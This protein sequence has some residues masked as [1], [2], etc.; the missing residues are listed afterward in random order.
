M[1]ANPNGTLLDVVGQM[2]NAPRIAALRG[3]VHSAMAKCIGAIRQDIRDRKRAERN[4]E[5]AQTDIDQRNQR[6]EDHR[7]SDAGDP[8]VTYAADEASNAMGFKPN[9][10]PLKQASILHAVYGYALDDLNTLTDNQWD[11]PLTLDAMLDFMMRGSRRLDP[12]FAAELAK[13]LNTTTEAL[14]KID[15]LQ[16]LRER[17]LL[18]QD[19]PEIKLTFEGFGDNAY[20]SAL[21][22]I[23]ALGQH[24]F[25]VKVVESLRKA[26]DQAIARIMRTRRLTDLSVIPLF[27]KAIADAS[28]W[29]KHFEKECKTEIRE[30]IDNGRSVRTLE[31]VLR[32]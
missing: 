13:L 22:E 27:D 21:E 23:P 20:E 24:Q 10:L 9:V 5:D 1:N 31:D 16:V 3:I 17:E 28:D 14:E 32:V 6:D 18:K 4:S 15:E 25:G 11:E 8:D 26:K 12:A 7:L 29:V 30:A 2:D 19:A